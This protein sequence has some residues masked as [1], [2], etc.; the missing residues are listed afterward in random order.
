MLELEKAGKKG[1]EAFKDLEEQHKKTTQ[2]AHVLETEL[3]KVTE[4][5]KKKNADDL[6]NAYKRLEK[7]T[8]ELK[9]QSK[10]LGA[11]MLEL[12]R[13]GKKNTKA[14]Y[15]LE[16]QYKKVTRSA[17][18]GDKALKNLDN[19]VGDN[20]RNV[21]NY[22]KAL[23]G[24]KKAL[25]SFGYAF[26]AFEAV[27]F[28]KSLVGTQVKLDSL[29]LSLKNVSDGTL[30][31][32]RNMGFVVNVSKQYGQ[33]L[34]S[35][36]DTYKNFIAATKDSNLSLGERQMIY[37]S[38]IKSSASLAQSNEDTEGT[39]RAVQQM[40]AK[41]KIQAEELTQQLGDRLPSAT[42]LMAK[43]VGV[44]TAELFKMMKKPAP[45]KSP[46]IN[47]MNKNA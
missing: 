3:K 22:G 34:L 45:P 30:E 5:T 24:L 32:N 28:I 43:A 16:N 19:R 17:Q 46:E 6:A 31:F 33:D 26:G 35:V 20:F 9:N 14:Y 10:Q 44:G 2:S 27:N 7:N 15:E 41:G 29:K 47:V 39:L 11:E 12:E 37:E 40:F 13:S 8:R 18:E 21:G 23:G 25:Q 4:P 38:L 42:R 36:I 1:T